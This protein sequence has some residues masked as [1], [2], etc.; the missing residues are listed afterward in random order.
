MLKCVLRGAPGQQLVGTSREACLCDGKVQ[1]RGEA[2]LRLLRPVQ[3]GPPVRGGGKCAACRGRDLAECERRGAMQA[4]SLLPGRLAVLRSGI[5][6]LDPG[7]VVV[8]AR[9]NAEGDL[10]VCVVEHD[11]LGGLFLL[12]GLALLLWVDHLDDTNGTLTDH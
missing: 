1:G 8:S 11:Y 6:Q 7:A 5:T 3:Q 12:P 2:A 10:V 4:G 9:R